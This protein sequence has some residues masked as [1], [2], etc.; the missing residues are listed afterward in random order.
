MSALMSQH[1][2]TSA[3]EALHKGI[4]CPQSSSY[5]CRRYILGGEVSVCQIEGDGQG[6]HVSGDIVEA[7]GSRSFEAV[8]RDGFV[9]VCNGVV[10]DLEVIAIGIDQLLSRRKVF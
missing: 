6:S 10:G 5:R 3:E 2:Q 1:P 8:L 7:G 9:D 4:Q